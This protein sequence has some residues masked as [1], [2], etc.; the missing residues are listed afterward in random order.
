MLDLD[1]VRQRALPLV[2]VCKK[3]LFVI[4]QFL[5]CLCGK[6]KVGPF[7]DGIDGARLLAEATVDTF[8]HIDVIPCCLARVVRTRRDLDRDC[9]RGAHR[10][11]QLAGNAALFARWVAPERVLAAETRRNWVLLK[12]VVERNAAG[13]GK[14]GWGEGGGISAGGPLDDTPLPRELRHTK[15]QTRDAATRT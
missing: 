12:G 5:S 4:Q 13:G 7:H 6:L 1:V 3:L 15:P 2:A 9:L 8:R 10:L 11:A 14:G